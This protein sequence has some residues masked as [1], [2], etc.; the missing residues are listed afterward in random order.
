LDLYSPQTLKAR[1]LKLLLKCWVAGPWSNLIRT[2]AFPFPSNAPLS[3]FIRSFAPVSQSAPRFGLMAGNPNTPGQR[4]I[5]LLLDSNHRP[6]VVLKVGVTLAAR[7]LIERE[8][9]FLTEHSE[10]F[11]GLPSVISHLLEDR[12]SALALH[13]V[14]GGP[15]GLEDY[16]GLARLLQ[17]WITPGARVRLGDFPAWK[18]LHLPPPRESSGNFPVEL[19]NREVA[20]TLYHG[21]LAPW[22][23]RVNA[24][25]EWIALDWERGETIGIPGWDWFHFHIQP[26]ILSK[27]SPVASLAESLETLLLNPDFRAYS[28]AVMIDGF[29]RP[30]IIAYLQYMML[31]IRPTEGKEML[32]E[33]HQELVERW[34]WN[35]QVF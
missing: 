17:S 4:F 9:A 16:Q 25:N 7:Q 29:E 3:K 18:K 19:E 23:V 22:N 28:K 13:H 14:P 11:P 12:I 20:A 35:D 10:K 27:R 21:D 32:Q 6:T 34:K 33:L 26:R 5:F 2:N 24:K 8:Y 31:V 1:A 30:L 15:P